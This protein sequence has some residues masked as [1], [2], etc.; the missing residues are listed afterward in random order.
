MFNKYRVYE[1]NPIVLMGDPMTNNDFTQTYL[2]GAKFG[3]GIVLA[4]G[5][6][7]IGRYKIS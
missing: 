6:A 5:N 4:G 3:A 7:G 2:Y 1:G